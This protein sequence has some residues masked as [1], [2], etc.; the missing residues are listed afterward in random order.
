MNRLKLTA[1]FGERDRTG[2]RFVADALA[3]VF[4][5]HQLEMS[6]VL[7]GI[8]GFGPAQRMRS[9]RLLSLSEDLPVVSIAVDR[10]ER[11]E[12]AL[13]DVEA[14]RFGGLVTV[15]RARS[16]V[17]LPGDLLAEAKL[18]LYVGRREHRSVVAA[19]HRHEVAGA[20]A[21]LGVDG[22]VRGSR[23]RARLRGGNDDVPLLVVSVGPGERVA[24]ALAELGDRLH[25]LERV[26]VCRRD[27]VALADLSEHAAGDPGPWQ[28]LTVYTSE[29]T[30]QHEQLVHR[31][32][33]AGA[34]G[35]TCL[36]GVWGYH[37]D[38]APH[39]DRLMQLRRRVPVVT[40]VVD[41]PASVVRLAPIVEDVTARTG[42]VTSELVPT[43]R[44]RA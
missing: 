30:G 10:P 8:A 20:T 31:L 24:A 17:A 14:L 26:R 2:D 29:A 19:L 9:D 35:A 41:T 21:L 4:A 1:Y 3:D 7:R 38:H 34:A 25:T 43:Y 15:E 37:G 32:R 42:L 22:T 39:G 18:T 12:A 44:E 28:K 6:I 40:V 5:G 16:E 33:R 36:R 11:V 27:G 23:R 13:R